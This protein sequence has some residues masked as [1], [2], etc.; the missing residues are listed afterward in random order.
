MACTAF[1]VTAGTFT[2]PDTTTGDVALTDYELDLSKW[3]ESATAKTVLMDWNTMKCYRKGN[4][5]TY[6]IK[7]T[8]LDSTNTGDPDPETHEYEC[9]SDHDIITYDE[10]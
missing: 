6:F 10:L 1:S 4:C 3:H 2:K 5:K 8:E 7:N 9:V